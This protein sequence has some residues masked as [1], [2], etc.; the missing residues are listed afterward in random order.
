MADIPL[1]IV[2]GWLVVPGVTAAGDTVDLIL[3]TGAAQGGITREM[4]TRLG[5]EPVD[6]VA[7]YGASGAANVDI[8][9]LPAI[10]VGGIDAGNRRAI[11]I[12]DSV[13][14]SD[15]GDTLAGIVGVPFLR[16]FDVL[17]DA[18]GGVLR[19]Y[20]RGAAPEEI[21]SVH[22][23]A[24]ALPFRL[25]G[26][27]LISLDATVNGQVVRGVFDTGARHLM[28]NWPAAERAG[29]ETSEDPVSE[30]RRGVGNEVVRSHG[31]R[32]DQL[33]LGATAWESVDAQVAD[34]PIF[35]ILGLGDLPTM[36]VG[37]PA[38]QGCPVLIS[39]ETK[40]LRL[41]RRPDA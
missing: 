12:A 35:R 6:N 14:A 13:L 8:V 26:S 34:L 38:V 32:I 16:R 1:R 20:A 7:A 23:S 5:L 27:G 21:P 39:Y 10:L 37:S 41:C 31:G 40:T 29:I 17:I 25:S 2:G 33:E 4:A 28:L 9:E 19:L 30:R 18:P 24:D 15:E 36:L 3:D 11:V 22:A